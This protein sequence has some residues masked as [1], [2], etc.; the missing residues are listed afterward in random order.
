MRKKKLLIEL[1]NFLNEN[2]LTILIE[3]FLVVFN[4][5]WVTDFKFQK[6]SF[7]LGAKF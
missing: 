7:N 6:A 5:I 3:N 1:D 4:K 2:N